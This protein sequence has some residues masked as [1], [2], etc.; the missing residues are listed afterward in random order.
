MAFDDVAEDVL[1]PEIGVAAAA[2]TA[3]LL[4]PQ[5]RRLLR[6]GAVYGI[7]GVFAAG[8]RVGALARRLVGGSEPADDKDFAHQLA[9]EARSKREKHT[10]ATSTTARATPSAPRTEADKQQDAT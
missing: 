10:S 7:S 4:T 8:D 3:V 5:A 2:V 9:A 6:R 1:Q